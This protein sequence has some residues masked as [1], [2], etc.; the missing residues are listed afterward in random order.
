MG[1]SIDPKEI[2]AKGGA[3]QHVKTKEGTGPS[4]EELAPYEKMYKDNGGDLSKIAAS[5]KLKFKDGAKVKDATDFAKQMLSG[6]L[7]AE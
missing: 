7:L 3:L 4:K 6:F 1:D 2:A 5:L